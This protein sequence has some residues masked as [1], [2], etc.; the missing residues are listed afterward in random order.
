MSRPAPIVLDD[1]REAFR[2]RLWAAQE[3]LCEEVVR[4]LD[5]QLISVSRKFNSPQDGWV[6]REVEV[7]VT[8]A[9]L[10]WE[11]DLVLVGTFAH[12]F[13]GLPTE[14]EINP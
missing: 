8:D 9:R 1:L 5:G 4:T 13:T 3:A 11:D 10:G 7:R 14:T 2:R 6:L 12:P